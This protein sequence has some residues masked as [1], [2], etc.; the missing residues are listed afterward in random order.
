MLSAWPCDSS[1]TGYIASSVAPFRY[2]A[3]SGPGT[4]EI[5]TL[6]TGRS[7]PA[8][9][10]QQL[11]HVR[12]HEQQRVGRHRRPRQLLQVRLGALGRGLDQREPM[13][14]VVLRRGEVRADEADGGAGLLVAGGA[15][16]HRQPRRQG[17]VR[18]ARRDSTRNRR[19]A[20][21]HTASTMSLTVAPASR[22]SAFTSSSATLSV[23]NRRCARH[24]A[25]DDR[26][27][28]RQ[29]RRERDRRP[30]QLALISRRNAEPTSPEHPDLLARASR[31]IP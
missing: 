30:A 4:F 18:Q 16:V 24:A 7:R 14:R 15:H 27:W 31:R 3:W 1:E 2:S 11:Q 5:V 12:R 28:A 20:P 29:R 25:V 17:R 21:L 23:A 19:S 8:E 9:P 6:N 26:P 10:G 22:A 13:H